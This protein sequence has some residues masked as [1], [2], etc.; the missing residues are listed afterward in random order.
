MDMKSLFENKNAVVILDTNVLLDVYRY[1]PQ[2][3][4]F[5]LECLKTICKNIMLP[6]T[7]KLEYDKHCKAEF[8]KMAG[9]VKN[10]S[11][12]TRNQIQRAKQKILN[13]CDGLERLRFDDVEELKTVLS[14]KLDGVEDVLNQFFEERTGLDLISHFWGD[15]DQMFDLVESLNNDNQIMKAPTQSEIYYWCEDGEKRY[16]NEVPPGFKDAKNKDG[17]RKYSDLI[18]WKE[19]LAFT[20][21]EKR[22]VFFVTDDVKADWW[23]IVDGKRVFHHALTE[24]FE[25][26]G[27]KIWAYTPNDFYKEVSHAYSI[28]MTD[29]V[30]L[31]LRMTD[32]AYCNKISDTV[33]EY[34][35][36]DLAYSGTEY[37]DVLSSH[38]GS[39]GIEELEIS[40]RG[41]QSAER[42]ARD[43]ETITYHLIYDIVAEGVSFEYWGR[44]DDT[45]EVIL[46]GGIHHV[47]NGQIEVEITREANVYLDFEA[48]GGFETARIISGDL[49]EVE[50][51]DYDEEA[52]YGELGPCPKCGRPL[53][54]ENSMG[55]FCNICYLEE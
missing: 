51:T 7:V 18:L 35:Q 3:S 26:T 54:Y 1:S 23:E 55:A 4:E 46:S 34:I 9:R 5:A 11:N 27:C 2:F 50:F 47:F 49:K 40:Q 6:A 15:R 10:A 53:T 43:D 44:D 31:A 33:F 52:E 28:E 21:R 20:T 12:E 41:L 29:T 45:K 30:E 25:K 39:E 24:E 32:D 16:K 37:I 17:V 22:N 19:I 8:A 36:D 13:A 48:D 14:Q 42:I 38:V